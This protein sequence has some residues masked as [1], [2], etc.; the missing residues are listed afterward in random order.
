MMFKKYY[1]VYSWTTVNDTLLY[2]SPYFYLFVSGEYYCLYI[3]A[4]E[5]W[6]IGPTFEH[7]KYYYSHRNKN[8][9]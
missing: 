4:L 9:V 5:R 3:Y 1:E 8:N 7:I 2:I 6:S